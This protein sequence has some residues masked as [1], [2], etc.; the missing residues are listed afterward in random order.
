MTASPDSQQVVVLTG[1]TSGIGRIA[2]TALAGQGAT[3]A[4]VGRNQARG[5]TLVG[6]AAPLDGDIRFHQ[7]DQQRKPPF[8]PSPRSSSIRMTGSMR[9]FTTQG[10]LHAIAQKRRR[11]SNSR[12]LLTTLLHTF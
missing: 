6:N 12:S 4:V 2:A 7:A 8:V 3:V 11:E 1:G 10:S 9:S 5:D